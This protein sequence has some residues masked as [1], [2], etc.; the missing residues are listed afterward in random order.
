M[1][2]REEDTRNL[3]EV[4]IHTVILV[5]TAVLAL[6]GNS[7]VCLAF[8]R[9]RRLR[10]I[11]N[12]YVLSL[13][14]SDIIMATFVS[15]F[16][17]VA[18]GFREWPFNHNFCQF[19]GFLV[20]YWSQLSLCILALASVNRYFCVIKPHR[21]PVLFTRKKTIYSVLGVWMF[22]LVQNLISISA[23]P[24]IFQWSPESLY[25]RATFLDERT[26][27]I[28]YLFFGCIFII[29][30]SLVIFCYGRIYR[31]LR[32]HNSVIV[33]S[34]QEAHSQ[35]IVTAQD[36]KAS[37]V[38]F[39]AVIGFCVCWLPLIFTFLLEYGFQITIPSIGRSIYPLFSCFSEWINPIIYGVMNR[40]M[41]KEFRNILFG[42]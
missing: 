7:L 32:H 31:V 37:R 35:E 33:P 20:Q 11:T 4:A 25:C 42:R 8:Y 19:A 39:A 22:F 34:L 38:I 12:F 28:C 29:P 40:T 21:Y 14:I 5:L 3:L 41:R 9:N 18:S 15:P 17:S 24:I 16:S 36:M 23:T 1:E 13:A 30:M 10:T 26:A 2:Q 27:R 6:T